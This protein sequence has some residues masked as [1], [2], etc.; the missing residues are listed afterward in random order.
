MKKLLKIT[1]IIVLISMLSCV[2]SGCNI[3]F[4]KFNVDTSSQQEIN[5][6]SDNN[7][8]EVTVRNAVNYTKKIVVTPELAATGYSNSEQHSIIIPEITSK[9]EN[10]KAFNKKMYDVFGEN[11]EK[12][13]NNQ[14]AQHIF[15]CKYKSKNYNGIIGIVIE[16]WLGVQAGGANNNYTAF[17]YDSKQDKE[18]TFDEYVT[19]LGLTKE[20]LWTKVQNTTAYSDAYSYAMG[21]NSV[22]LKDCILDSTGTVVY[23]NDNYTMMGWNHL[24]IEAIIQ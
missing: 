3:E 5:E 15:I 19:A 7:E 20:E 1:S 4:G 18:L 8:K 17:Y 10:A 9:T 12:L 22:S 23:L 2:I 14:E 13:L 21:D 24:E 11:Y 6:E 16:T